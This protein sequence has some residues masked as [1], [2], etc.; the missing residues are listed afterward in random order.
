MHEAK[1]KRR[2]E[3]LQDIDE[4][5]AENTGRQTG[6][7]WM[8]QSASSI[9]YFSTALSQPLTERVAFRAT[10]SVQPDVYSI[11]VY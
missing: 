10:W 5:A 3:K 8:E 4:N 1:G 7:R 9:C 11:V 2:S 6:R